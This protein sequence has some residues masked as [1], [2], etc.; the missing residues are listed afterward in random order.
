LRRP[1]GQSRDHVSFGPAEIEIEHASRGVV[2]NEQW[3][4]RA[5]VNGVFDRQHNLD[6]GTGRKLSGSFEGGAW[7]CERFGHVDH[8]GFSNLYPDE[9]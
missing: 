1:I 4:E 8:S 5:A 2:E 6:Q 7:L 3:L 9:I